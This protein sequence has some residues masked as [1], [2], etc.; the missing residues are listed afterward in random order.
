LVV[1][2][3]VLACEAISEQRVSPVSDVAIDSR[4]S[5]RKRILPSTN[6]SPIEVLN[7]GLVVMVGETL[8]YEAIVEL[9]EV[10][11]SW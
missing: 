6:P 10:L 4:G 3:S 1:V 7:V 5:L 2:N 11:L 9:G 8:S